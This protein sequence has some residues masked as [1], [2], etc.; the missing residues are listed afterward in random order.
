MGL[1]S[2]IRSAA[3][4]AWNST[5]EIAKSVYNGVKEFVS[6]TYNKVKEKVTNV[7]NSFSGKK[8]FD[9]AEEL[10]NKITE[11]YNARRKRFEQET[12]DLVFKIEKH[13]EVINQSKEKI[14]KELFRDMAQKLSKIKDIQIS[15]DFSIETYMSQA[16]SFDKIRS[17]EQLYKIDFNKNKF[18]AN[19]LAIFTLGFYTRKKAK[20]TLYAVQEE[21]AKIDTEI[22]KMDA[23]LIKLQAIEMS[24]ANVEHYFTSLIELYSNLLVRLD[25]AVNFLYVRCMN[26]AHKLVHAEM[27]IRRLP[28]MQQKEVEAIIT[29]SKILKAMTDAQ[30][31]TLENRD[32]VIKY[33]QQMKKHNLELKKVYEA[34]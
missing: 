1:W 28:K 12:T 27:S 30:I 18:K 29:A 24:L 8:T 6:S 26:F 4:S 31:L 25:S 33:D 10:Y 21:E 3:K 7:W 15:E 34:A 23:E 11:R 22:A 14:K 16:L 2:S 13:V 19:V 5:K 20:E 9:E 17:K 32:T